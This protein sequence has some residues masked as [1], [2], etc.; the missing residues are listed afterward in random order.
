M[1]A[2]GLVVRAGVDREHLLQ[3]V[4]RHPIAHHGAEP[5]LKLI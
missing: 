4:S 2:Q 1:A 3:Q 5:G